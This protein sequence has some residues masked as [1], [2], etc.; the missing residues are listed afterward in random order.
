MQMVFRYLN[1][2]ESTWNSI[3]NHYL[4]PLGS[5]L[6]CWSNYKTSYL[7]TKMPTFYEEVLT[8]WRQYIENSQ[9]DPSSAFFTEENFRSATLILYLDTKFWNLQLC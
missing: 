2:K 8:S 5:D 9:Q 7:S 1:R 4:K 6:L 3:I